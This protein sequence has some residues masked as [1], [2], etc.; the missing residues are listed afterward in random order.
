M[1]KKISDK[2]AY[3]KA[4]KLETAT[5]KARELKLGRRALMKALSRKRK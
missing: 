5:E 1:G 4:E 3:A 2:R